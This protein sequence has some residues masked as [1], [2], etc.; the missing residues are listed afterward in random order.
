MLREVSQENISGEIPKS[1]VYFL[2]RFPSALLHCIILIINII[3]H[4]SITII[5]GLVLNCALY[6][7]CRHSASFTFC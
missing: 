1:F 3:K 6:F 5:L 4:I 2:S 7:L